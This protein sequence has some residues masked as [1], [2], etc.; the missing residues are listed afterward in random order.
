MTELREIDLDLIDEPTNAHRLGMSSSGLD[1]LADSIKAMGLLNPIIV[2]PVDGERFEIIA[3]HRRYIAH[4]MLRRPTIL[5]VVRT[6]DDNATEDAR[7]AENLQREQLS[8]MEEAVSI[9]RYMEQSGKDT[10][11]VAKALN[12]TE[13]WVS[14]RVALHSM[15]DEL[16]DLVH[17]ETLAAGAALELAKVTDDAHRRYLTEFTVRSG[18]NV[19]VVREW[20]N[21]W[22]ISKL[23][24]PDADAP[25]PDLPPVGQEVIVTI[26]C[27]L[28]G[29]AHDHR[30]MAIVRVCKPC[31]RKVN[32]ANTQG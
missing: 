25:K 4:R 3:G 17:Q 29:E 13:W 5:C 16:K 21:Q 8:P 15:P 27:Y 18:A 24:D 30:A 26:P 32:E 23:A 28:C 31:V 20:V 14:H 22:E 10:K 6:A 7:F 11:A 9:I 19:G 12:R 1:E 2:R